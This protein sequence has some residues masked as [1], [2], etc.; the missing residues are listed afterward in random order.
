M[1]K[2]AISGKNAGCFV[3]F[4]GS[5]LLE[6]QAKLP[7]YQNVV[8]AVIACIPNAPAASGYLKTH[9]TKESP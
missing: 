1:V 2:A 8:D 4:S 6:K 7:N 5:L 3:V 9:P